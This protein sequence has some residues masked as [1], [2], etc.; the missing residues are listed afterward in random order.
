MK[1]KHLLIFVFILVA[2]VPLFLGL[3]TLNHY[4]GAHYR[5]LLEEHLASLS[6]I[7]KKRV[8]AVIERI[9][10]N[11]VLIAS[12]TQMRMSL[13][14]WNQSG[15]PS[16]LNIIHRILD[17]ARNGLQ[18]LKDISIYDPAGNLVASTATQ[19][20]VGRIDPQRL[21][22]SSIS[23]QPE[24][25]LVLIISQAPLNLNHQTIGYIRLAFFTEFITDLVSDRTGL[26]ETGEWLFAVRHESGDALFT[27]PLKYDPD[28]AFNRRV[29]KDRLDIP[30]TQAL[31]G[32]ERILSEAPDYV[33]TPVLASTRYISDLDWGL[34]AKINEE[35]VNRQVNQNRTF[36][37]ILE[38]VIVALAILAGI[39]LSVYIAG[40]IEKLKEYTAKVARG[41]FEEP[42]Q[43]GGW[44]EVKELTT[45]FTYMI[46]ALKDLNNNLQFKV[47][48]RTKAL[49]QANKKL[50]RMATQD[51]LTGLHNRRYFNDSLEQEIHRARRYGHPLA[52]VILDI[53]HFKRIND[54]F[55]HPMGDRVLKAVADHLMAAVRETDVVSR[56]GGEEFCL[57]L[58]ESSKDSALTFLE[59][60]RAELAEIKF[61]SDGSEFSVTSSFGVAFLGANTPDKDTLMAHADLAL[62]QAKQGGRNRIM[63]YV[64]DGRVEPVAGHKKSR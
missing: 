30:T 56:I 40:P 41:R 1:L 50:A 32:N 28:A 63:Q 10:D 11:S 5:A 29:S 23:L 43:S 60:I 17:D 3:Q 51:P 16:H 13:D 2:A 59:R 21:T 20:L 25:D 4:T 15:D 26:G 34:V 7:A 54:N 37:Y 38:L 33:G 61:S 14:Q 39:G 24:G 12:R 44:Q 58:P 22:R 19:P 8:L 27:V 49:H 31:L 64:G 48:E 36:I 55:G 57:I 9:E 53:D 52:L 6:L 46:R 18:A 42:P 62:Y 45:D 35:E 47:A